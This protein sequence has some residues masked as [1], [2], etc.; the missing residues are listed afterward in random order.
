MR[1]II[2][3][4]YVPRE[5]IANMMENGDYS[6]FDELKPV[7]QNA[8]F[9]II[10]LEAPIV[11][12]EY[13]HL[14]KCG[15]NLKTTPKVIESLKYLG[16]DMVT[17]A[18]NHILDYGPNGIKD[19][20]RNL[21]KA[22]IYHSG[23]GNNLLDA[24]EIKY[25]TINS[26]T[27]AIINCC[28]HEFSIATANTPGANPLNS[29]QQYYDINE[30]KKNADHVLVIVHGGH[31]YWPF[32]STRMIETYRFFVDSG[33]D[34]VVNHHQHC[35][36]GFEIYKSK[37]IVY[38]LGNLCFEWGKHKNSNWDLGYLIDINF[39]ESISLNIIPYTQCNKNAKVELLP[40]DAFE[41][42]ISKINKII[43][44]EQ[45]IRE[46]TDE[47]YKSCSQQIKKVFEPYSG[48]ILNKLYS[49][50]LL[51]SWIKGDKLNMIKN[52]VACESHRDKVLHNL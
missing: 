48:R 15:P 22:G 26:E 42:E 29:I 10:N 44:D 20:I 21:D 27:I 46:L 1:I 41:S 50:R 52:Y 17:L 38:G 31:E 37:P 47:Y 49:L 3:G 16:V 40:K 34:A 2:G 9:S 28:E 11:E 14:S 4:D 33:A 24:R 35:Y 30:A 6:Y 25:I 8:D 5:N 39:A 7:F 43:S 36:S 45:K 51:P 18:N 19:T 13:V 32:P 23:V 12:G